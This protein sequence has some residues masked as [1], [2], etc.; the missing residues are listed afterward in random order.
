MSSQPTA[1]FYNPYMIIYMI[2]GE[3]TVPATPEGATLTTN[4]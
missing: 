4:T 3:I 2:Q 1:S